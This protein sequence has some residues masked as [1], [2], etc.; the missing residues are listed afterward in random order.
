MQRWA[1]EGL[2]RGSELCRTHRLPRRGAYRRPH[3]H[4]ELAL[5]IEHDR[6]V[7]SCEH[8]MNSASSPG[9]SLRGRTRNL[10]R[11]DGGDSSTVFAWKLAST[12]RVSRILQKRFQPL[13][14]GFEI[15]VMSIRRAPM[16][17]SAAIIELA[18]VTTRLP[19]IFASSAA[20]SASRA[21]LP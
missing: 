8:A 10:L 3:G 13:V 14:D 19:V 12:R 6:R 2:P 11:R 20:T 1:L 18:V 5:E 16:C 4:A 21:G 9:R 17:S 7:G 15:R